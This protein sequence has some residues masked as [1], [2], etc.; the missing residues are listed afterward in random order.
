MWTKEDSKYLRS[1]RARRGITAET[2][3]KQ[4]GVTRA[5]LTNVE[6]GRVKKPGE[7]LCGQLVRLLRTWREDDA[8]GL[9]LVRE[10]REY[11]ADTECPSCGRWVPGP[12]QLP[13]CGECGHAF[14]VALC[15]T[16][17]AQGGRVAAFCSGCGV[18][19]R[20]DEPV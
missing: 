1:A 20:P 10:D 13:C 16:C 2:L 17:K 9:P 4:L 12:G 8:A 7:P 5:T 14:P 19:L 3:A 18:A 6:L 11:Y 15:N